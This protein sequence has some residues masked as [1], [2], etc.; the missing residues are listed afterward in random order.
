V[1]TTTT[2]AGVA[3]GIAPQATEAAASAALRASGAARRDETS[4]SI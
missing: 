4:L 3:C 1:T 2:G